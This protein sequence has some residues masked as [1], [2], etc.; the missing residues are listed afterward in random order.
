ML[1]ATYSQAAQLWK[2]G[3]AQSKVRSDWGGRL[4]VRVMPWAYGMGVGVVVWS[5]GHALD[6]YLG[7]GGVG[8]VNWTHGQGDGC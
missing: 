5:P 7:W 3:E 6:P 1:A 2:V 8:D 4:G